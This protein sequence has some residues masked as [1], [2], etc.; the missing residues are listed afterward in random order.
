MYNFYDKYENQSKNELLSNFRSEN[1]AKI[2]TNEEKLALLQ[3]LENRTAEE[4]GR[5][6]CFIYELYDDD[7]GTYGQYNDV[8]NSIGV[9]L[10]KHIGSYDMLDTVYH[11][12]EHA[13]QTYCVSCRRAGL[14]MPDR[15]LPK[16]TLDMCEVESFRVT[17]ENVKGGFIRELFNIE[18]YPV[19]SFYNYDKTID[20]NACLCEL[21]SETV[22]ANRIMENRDIWK[23]DAAY[24]DYLEKYEARFDSTIGVIDEKDVCKMQK[25]AINESYKRGD[26]SSFRRD[27]MLKN[28]VKPKAEQPAIKSYQD[29]KDALSE[30]RYR[31][32]LENMAEKRVAESEKLML[33]AEAPARSGEFKSIADELTERT[34]ARGAVEAPE[35]KGKVVTAEDELASRDL[36]SGEDNSAYD[37][38]AAESELSRFAPADGKSE[39]YENKESALAS[40]DARGRESGEGT[41]SI[42]GHGEENGV[43]NASSDGEHNV[44][45]NGEGSTSNGTSNGNTPW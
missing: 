20:Y 40:F 7:L 37:F 28:T 6:A 1:Y 11:E 13:F 31:V 4:Q 41:D 3:A 29:T 16:E 44:S 24:L 26:I 32:Y 9:N 18:D 15:E 33:E 2:E 5:P 21:D 8:T 19:G 22:A 17:E 45:G 34:I 25:N 14:P 38:E 43:G 42:S 30:E 12:G 23:G 35:S 10:D 39:S 36:R 27:D